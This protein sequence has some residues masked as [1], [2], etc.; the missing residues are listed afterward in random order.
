VPA[1]LVYTAFTVFDAFIFLNPKRNVN[2][3]LRTVARPILTVIFR[4]VIYFFFSRGVE[5]S[6]GGDVKLYGLL[7]MH[8]VLQ[9]ANVRLATSCT[10]MVDL[11]TVL[12]FD[13]TFWLGRS[14]VF[15]LATA[16]KATKERYPACVRTLL[17]VQTFDKIHPRDTTF[18]RFSTLSRLSGQIGDE[19]KQELGQADYV[20]LHD[21]RRYEYLLEN[22]ALTMCCESHHPCAHS[23]SSLLT[24]A[25]GAACVSHRNP[26]WVRVAPR[27]RH[28]RRQPS[29]RFLVS[30]GRRLAAL[31]PHRF[32][33]G[34]HPGLRLT[35]ACPRRRRPP[36]QLCQLH[37][38]VARLADATFRAVEGAQVRPGRLVGR[39]RTLPVWLLVLPGG[40]PRAGIDVNLRRVARWRSPFGFFFPAFFVFGNRVAPYRWS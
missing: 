7:T 38:G 9:L 33:L 32:R 29:P 6:R 5:M 12:V 8:I 14:F 16:P 25:L 40:V 3:G 35:H 19:L 13:W 37:R 24:P 34:A 1:S 20:Q 11:L 28:G 22:A 26:H 23:F 18:R 31:H 10:S 27:P 39:R 4:R 36:P 17:Y 2:E 15:Y 21:L 30:D